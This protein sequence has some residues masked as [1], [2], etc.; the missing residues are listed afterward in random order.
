M[1]RIQNQAT[2]EEQDFTN[3]AALLYALEGEEQRC[4][5]LNN[6]ATFYL[7]HLDKKDEVLESMELTIP[8]SE[9]QDVKELLGD[10]GLKGEAKK[11][12][13]RRQE[14]QNTKAQPSPSSKAGSSKVLKGLIWLLPLLLS[15]ASF[16]LSLQV[17]QVVKTKAQDKPKIE[18]VV[19]NQK[20]DVFCRYFISSYFSQGP[21]LGDYLSE[22]L[23]I[24][25]LKTDKVTPVSVL[26]ESQEIKGNETLVTYVVNIKDADDHVSSKRL[27]LTVKAD[28]KAKYGYLVTKK[29]K[30]TAYP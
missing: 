7:F 19:T 12:F 11:S 23:S 5:Q 16:S 1:F 10:F 4:L 20:A 15:L 21:N 26:L 2:G 18:T 3:R 8:S 28:K 14:A 29:P 6:S 9:G 27:T 22:K 13:W 25:D 17:L 24:D 30:L